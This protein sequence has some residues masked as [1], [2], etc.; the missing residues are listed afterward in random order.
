[1][2]NRDVIFSL[3]K[4]IN[5]IVLMPLH[6]VINDLGIVGVIRYSLAWKYAVKKVYISL[7]IKKDGASFYLCNRKFSITIMHKYLVEPIMHFKENDTIYIKTV[8]K[9]TTSLI[10]YSSLNTISFPTLKVTEY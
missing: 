8:T 7:D 10:E 4:D 9:P 3:Y 1:M 6:P 5:G 2:F